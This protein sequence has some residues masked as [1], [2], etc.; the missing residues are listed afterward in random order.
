MGGLIMKNYFVRYS[1]FIF[2]V[3]LSS[4]GIALTTKAA[5]GTTPISSVPYVLSFRFPLSFGQITFLINLLFILGQAL[6]LRKDFRP[7][8]LLQIGVN[9]IFSSCID[10][11]MFLLSWFHPANFAIQLFSLLAGCAVLSLGISIEVAPDV[12]MVP[13]EG[14]V[15]A[16]SIAFKRKFGSI[17]VIFDV[18]LM[19]TAC[20][21]SLLFFHRIQGLGPGT[22]ISALIVGRFVNMWNK[23]LPLISYIRKLAV[24]K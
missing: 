18:T 15:N 24:K 6:L 9:L 10:L 16:M 5:M 11:G 1:W 3:L 2:G 8:Q 23:R 22:I 21:L 13:G 14:I 4:L 17:K 19:A 20:A 12:L 7:I